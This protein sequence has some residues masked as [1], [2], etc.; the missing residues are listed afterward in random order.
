[1]TVNALDTSPP[2]P[3]LRQ[4]GWLLALLIAIAA[5]QVDSSPTAL[6][7][8]ALAALIFTFAAV[9][10]GALC[11]P[12]CVL[13]VATAPIRWVLGRALLVLAYYGLL[14][15]LALFLRLVRRDALRW[16]LE[17]QAPTYWQPRVPSS[18]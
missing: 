8:K 18:R 11:W 12:Y 13:A 14:T 4:F 10:P 9:W 2:R 7:L 16:R 5:G 1:M 6:A 17:P 3:Q 15:P